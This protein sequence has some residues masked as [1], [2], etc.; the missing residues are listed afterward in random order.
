MRFLLFLRFCDGVIRVLGCR[1]KG[2]R[3]LERVAIMELRGG[4]GSGGGGGGEAA[5]EAR[6]G[7]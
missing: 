7:E 5:R 3:W 2:R 4:G 6:G 1:G